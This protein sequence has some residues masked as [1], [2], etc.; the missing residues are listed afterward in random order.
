M[1]LFV[2]SIF[3][4]SPSLSDSL[5]FVPSWDEILLHQLSLCPSPKPILTTYP[6]GYE[7]PNKIPEVPAS[8]PASASLP[9]ALLIQLSQLRGVVSRFLR[10]ISILIHAWPQ[11]TRPTYLVAKGFGS[12]SMLRL[13]GRLL[14]RTY[15]FVSFSFSLAFFP[16]SFSPFASCWS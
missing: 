7:L 11:D 16:S 1:P 13:N 10:I 6:P 5:R 2:R 12:D 8:D 3:R 15:E 4:I 9:A 14:R